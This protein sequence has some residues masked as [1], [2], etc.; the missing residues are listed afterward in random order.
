MNRRIIKLC[1]FIL[2]GAIANVAVAWGYAFWNHAVWIGDNPPNHA[3]IE[4]AERVGV[5]RESIATV[6]TMAN[7]GLSKRVLYRLLT[8]RESSFYLESMPH[9]DAVSLI[10]GFPAHSVTGEFWVVGADSL[11]PAWQ[12]TGSDGMAIQGTRDWHF[13]P[14]KPLWP[15]FAINTVFYAAVLWV[16]FAAVI[17]GPGFVRRRV[18]IWRGRCAACGYNLRATTTGVCSEC[19]RPVNNRLLAMGN[20]Q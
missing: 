4:W 14:A 1:A 9:A 13:I 18:R 2:A 3:D 16:L 8:P 5:Q 20:R 6:A 12:W 11:D 17:R 15:G 10:A 7:E 19:G